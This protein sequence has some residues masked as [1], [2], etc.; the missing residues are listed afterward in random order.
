M[1]KRSRQSPRSPAVEIPL[2]PFQAALSA[3]SEREQRFILNLLQDPE[4][5]ASKAYEHAGYR[6]RGASARANASECLRRP[7]VVAAVAAG[8][9]DRAEKAS[10]DAS[11]VLTE[12]SVLAHSDLTHYVIND[13]GRVVLAAGAPPDAMKALRSI[14]KKVFYD[15]QGNVTGR[16][17]EVSLW[18][19]PKSLDLEGSHLGLWKHVIEAV[20][21]VPLFVLPAGAVPDMS[22]HHS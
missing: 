3:C 7:H 8:K 13:D 22:G 18:D 12:V 16:Q 21:N 10:L 9:A 14:K 6:A 17:V 2:T 4:A 5:N 1:A 11:K 19:K 15:K 20:R